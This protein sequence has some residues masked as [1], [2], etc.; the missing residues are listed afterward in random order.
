MN[1]SVHR[2]PIS[3]R[4]EQML[5]FGA[6]GVDVYEKEESWFFKDFTVYESSQ[7]MKDWDRRLRT[8][9][10]YPNVMITPHS[11]FL[12]KEALNNIAQTT[13]SREH[14]ELGIRQGSGDQRGQAPAWYT[15][16]DHQYIYIGDQS[17][18][19]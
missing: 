16:S 19:R 1:I 6:L 9:F 13:I 12:T 11:T 10:S 2:S 17:N 8:L 5:G 15:Y 7:R 3:T 14:L 18:F 4:R